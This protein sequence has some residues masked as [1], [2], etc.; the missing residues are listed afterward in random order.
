M[1]TIQTYKDH[2]VGS[3]QVDFDFPFP[4]LDDSHVIVQL[5][6]STSESP[7]GK[8]Y[9]VASSNY[10]IITSPATLIRFNTAPETGA[11]LRIKRYSNASTALV[12]FENGSVL[13]E[14]ELDRAYLHNLYLNEEIEEG[15]GKNAMT[16]N[17]AGNFEADLAKIVDLADP[18]A[19]QDAATK[20]YVDTEITTE[21]TAR[22]ADVDAEETARIAGDA[23]KVAKAGDTMTG[24]LGMGSNKVTSSATPSTGNDLTNKTYVDAGDA[25]QVNKTGDS[26]S[27][28]LAMGSNKI[29]GLGTP[30]ASTD[31][32]NKSYVDAEI[33]ATL[34]TGVAGGPIDTANIA[35]D[36]VTADKLA[37]TA[38]TPAAYTN[39]NITVDQQGRITAASNGTAGGEDN[40][41]ANWTEADSGSDAFIQ[42]KPT[43]GTA[44][45]SDTSDFAAASH[46]HTASNITGFDTAVSDNT[47]VQANTAKVTNATHTGDVTGSTTLTIA[48]NAITP[49][50]ISSTE[51]LL[52]VNDT[53]GTIGIGILANSSS[54]SPKI[55]MDGNVQI[56]NQATTLGSSELAVTGNGS[57]HILTVENTSSTATDTSVL[58][59]KGPS[60]TVQL[61]DT[62]APTNSGTYNIVS[63]TGFLSIS[64]INDNGTN[65]Q[66]VL[67]IEPDGQIHMKTGMT[68]AFDL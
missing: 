8:F 31:A 26:M 41:Q 4:Y 25:D 38:V 51:T 68:I 63:N 50:K 12:D 66:E 48:D 57:S 42:N 37:H 10:T 36:A 22:I 24:D 14:V 34:A 28:E 65:R 3:G 52:N 56:G 47:D 27:G 60:T 5:D 53:Q 45:A 35:D 19:A 55:K 20:N 54:S 21:R 2:I 64:S 32:T 62:V 39:A 6:D 11:R 7:G 23:L 67:R 44:A 1:S 13:T 59:V 46:T 40:V 15:S 49:A 33:A 9:T 16:K 17:S 58:V 61:N 43:L 29:T 30:S 18:T